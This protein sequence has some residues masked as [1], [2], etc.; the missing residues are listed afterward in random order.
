MT[1]LALIWFALWLLNACFSDDA[2]KV[3]AKP[4]QSGGGGWVW[5]IIIMVAIG[6][7]AAKSDSG[8]SDI[9]DTA[10]SLISGDSHVA[11]NGSYFGQ[12]SEFNG[13]PKTVYREGY[14][15]SNGWVRGHYRSEP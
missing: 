8:S 5:V 2:E 14:Q 3:P 7:F 15:R 11:P 12:T 1:T 6:W 13:R 9:G 10:T 4:V